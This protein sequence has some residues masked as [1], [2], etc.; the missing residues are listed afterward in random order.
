FGGRAHC[1]N[2]APGIGGNDAEWRAV[3]DRAGQRVCFGQLALGVAALGDIHYGGPHM[4]SAVDLERVESDLE[5]HLAA[6]LATAVEFAAECHWPAARALHEIAALCSMLMTK[7][8][9]H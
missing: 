5:R 2:D 6:I 8:L 7:P 9:R 1:E 4:R 3:D